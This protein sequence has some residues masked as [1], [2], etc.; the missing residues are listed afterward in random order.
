MSI[1]GIEMFWAQLERNKVFA[2]K[3]LSSPNQPYNPLKTTTNNKKK[4]KSKKH[5]AKNKNQKRKVLL[6]NICQHFG[7]LTTGC[8][9]RFRIQGQ[10]A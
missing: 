7:F 5:K 6:N 1:Y 4:I 10:T 2:K 3:K 9:G 8:Q